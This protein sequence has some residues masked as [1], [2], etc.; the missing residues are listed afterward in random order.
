MNATHATLVVMLLA[1]ASTGVASAQPP[2]ATGVEASGT[3]RANSMQPASAR[4]SPL[5]AGRDTWYEYL[6]KQFNPADR[7][8]GAWMEQHRR[9]LLDAS[10]HNPYFR[11][12]ATVTL[13][14]LALSMLCAKLWID[15]RRAMWITSE[16][17]TDLYNHDAYSRRAAREAIAK[18]N[19][20]IERC[21]RAIEAAANGLPLSGM[22]SEVELLR[23]ELQAVADER[24]SY[25][26]ERE[27]A[28]SELAEKERLL[29]DMSMRLDALAKRSETNRGARVAADAGDTDQKLVKHINTLQEQLYNERREN[30]RLKG[31]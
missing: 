5:Y 24:D 28:R 9:A 8:Y 6:L 1:L 21:N 13:G 26:R 22:D 17:M 7:D 4:S 20:H 16:M 2:P 23:H 12:S 11:Y 15:H 10:L 31:A 14:L 29:A 30:K 18:Y 19:Q 3:A 25:R 27:L